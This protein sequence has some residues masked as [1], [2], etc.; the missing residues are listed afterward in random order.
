MNIASIVWL[1]R[2]EGEKF[3]ELRK[4][5]ETAR[6]IWRES[7]VTNDDTEETY[8]GI[9]AHKESFAALEGNQ[10]EYDPRDENYWADCYEESGE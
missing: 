4:L 7:E 2:G 8:K 5:Y 9:K 3:H 1:Y 6:D 10:Y